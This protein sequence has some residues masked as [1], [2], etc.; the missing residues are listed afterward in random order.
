MKLEKILNKQLVVSEMRQLFYS[1]K[2]KAELKGKGAIFEKRK[3]D[4][5]AS[6]FKKNLKKVILYATYSTEM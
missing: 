3:W 5:V 4:T 2:Y 1:E 6:Y